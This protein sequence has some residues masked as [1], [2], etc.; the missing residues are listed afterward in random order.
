MYRIRVRPSNIVKKK[1]AIEVMHMLT[2]TYE[3]FSS[4]KM[5][6][7]SEVVQTVES[8]YVQTAGPLLADGKTYGMSKQFIGFGKVPPPKPRSPEGCCEG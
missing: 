2:G 5:L 1:S 6:G 4:V 8:V 7:Q 3:M